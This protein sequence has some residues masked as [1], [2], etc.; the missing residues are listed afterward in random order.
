MGIGFDSRWA[1]LNVANHINSYSTKL[2]N[3]VGR[4]TSGMRI[5]TAADD[6]AGLTIDQ[7]VRDRIG[8]LDQAA[9]NA[10]NDT[11]IL[12]VADNAYGE[13]VGIL[14]RMKELAVQASDPT[15]ETEGRAALNIEFTTLDKRLEDLAA[16][17]K[18]GNLELFTDGS[19]NP[20]LQ[21]DLT[22][23]L[24][25]DVGT[26]LAA[27]VASDNVIVATGYTLDDAAKSQEVVANLDGN[28]AKVLVGQAQVGAYE[29]TLGYINEGIQTES[30]ALQSA[31]TQAFD[32]DI[33][34]EMTQYVKNSVLL[35]SAQLILSQ[36]NQ[37]AYSVLNLLSN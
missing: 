9:Q 31:H 34:R 10:Q 22:F 35:Q 21:K 36:H 13:A 29:N 7:K 20:S 17:T 6:P 19:N 27:T 4:I 2:E 15:M 1:S 5:N 24:G 37:N 11:A 14:Q 3:S 28:L 26:Q 32:T 18:Y 25:A 16:N 23:M 33:A 12:K 30:T 8:A